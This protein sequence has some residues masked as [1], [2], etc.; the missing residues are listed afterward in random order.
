MPSLEP[1]QP[2]DPHRVASTSK[3]PLGPASSVPPPPV[4]ESN[5]PPASSAL[6]VHNSSFGGDAHSAV[7]FDN[8]TND[9]TLS[10]YS[11]NREDGATAFSFYYNRLVKFYMKYNPE[12]LQRAEEFLKAYRGEEEQLFALLTEKYGPEPDP[13][14]QGSVCSNSDV[15]G[16]RHLVPRYVSKDIGMTDDTTPYWPGSKTVSDRDLCEVLESTKCTNQDLKPFF[17]GV[18]KE[19]PDTATNGLTYITAAPV[20][21]DSARFLGHHWTGSLANN[22]V[23]VHR[24]VQYHR[25]VLHCTDE[26]STPSFNHERWRLT[27]YRAEHTPLVLFRVVW[28]PVLQLESADFQQQPSRLNGSFGSQPAA[29]GAGI[30]GSRFG[31]SYASR[32]RIPPPSHEARDAVHRDAAV[33]GIEP[34]QPSQPTQPVAVGNQPTQP[35]Q[36]SQPVP[37]Q[38]SQP[39][40][41]PTSSDPTA[42]QQQPQTAGAEATMAMG[43]EAFMQQQQQQFEMLFRYLGQMETRLGQR[44]TQLEDRFMMLEGALMEPDQPID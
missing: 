5:A 20:P 9:E 24:G 17:S 15:G 18:L 44:M 30:G 36:P 8:R 3:P 19:H 25:T 26:C 23:L 35:V 42:G 13:P 28:D 12:K 37:A 39:V 7:T 4:S 6:A 2:Y 10:G 43:L 31:V 34:P 21:A 40:E 1:V 14:R 27:M 22:K 41:Q 29:A 16:V 38:P 32:R 11:G 33:A